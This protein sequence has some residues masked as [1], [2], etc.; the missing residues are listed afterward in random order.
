MEI[1][2]REHNNDIKYLVCSSIMVAFTTNKLVNIFP[3][4]RIDLSGQ[5]GHFFSLHCHTRGYCNVV[6]EVS[7]LMFERV[8]KLGL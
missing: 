8:Q 2:I 3:K 4:H 7:Q 6:A 5:I 1:N